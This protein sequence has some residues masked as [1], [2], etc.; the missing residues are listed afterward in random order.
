MLSSHELGS[1]TL[2]EKLRYIEKNGKFVDDAK[3]K[4]F[5]TNVYWMGNGSDADAHREYY[6]EIVYNSVENKIEY[7][8]CREVFSQN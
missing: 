1:L 8:I 2:D 7:I 3:C 4:G 5:P 6:A